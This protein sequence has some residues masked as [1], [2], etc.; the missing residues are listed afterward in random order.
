[1]LS[2]SEEYHS[3]LYESGDEKRI[4]NLLSMVFTEWQVKGEKALPHWR[5]KYLDNPLGPCTVSVVLKE[6]E[7]V[8]AGHDLHFYMKP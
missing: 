3:R 6:D 4:A 2:P 1:M 7:I 8:A 5:W